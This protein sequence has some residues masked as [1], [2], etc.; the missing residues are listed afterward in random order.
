MSKTILVKV[1]LPDHVFNVI[2]RSSELQNTSM[3]LC[4]QNYLIYGSYE[5]IKQT[6]DFQTELEEKITQW[7]ESE[8]ITVTSLVSKIL[9][10]DYLPKISEEV[11]QGVLSFQSKI[12]KK[13]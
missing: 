2:K 4:I 5:I 11:Y 12:N 1:E 8:G 10:E 3:D 13:N 6:E 9:Q 7:A